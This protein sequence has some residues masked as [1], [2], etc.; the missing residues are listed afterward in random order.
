MKT[1][2]CTNS[3]LLDILVANGINLVCNENMQIVV[4]EEDAN[5]IETIVEELAPAA[6]QDYVIE[7][8]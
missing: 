6:L 8:I 1:L 7:D 3:E 4:S 5:K 2:Y